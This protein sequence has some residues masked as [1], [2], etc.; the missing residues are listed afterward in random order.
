[1]RILVQPHDLAIGG[2]QLNAIDLAVAMRDRGH[3]VLM[4][5][6]PGVLVD[7]IRERGLEFIEAPHVAHRPGRAVHDRLTGLIDER[8][9]NVLHGYEWPPAV[10]AVLAARSR[11]GVAP[12][13][14]VMSMSVAPFLPHALPLV[15]GTEQIGAVERARGRTAVTVIEPPVD[16]AANDPS[17][18]DAAGFARRYGLDDGV[19]TVV[20]VSRLAQQL[21]LEGLL[22]A[23]DGAGRI[24]EP[25]R[26]VIVGDGVA[27]GDV[28]AAAQRVN[29]ERG[30]RRVI[31]TGELTDPRPAYA[32]ASAVLGM[33]GSALR[34][35]AFGKPLIVQGESGFF[36]LLTADSI[37]QFLWR[38][39]YGVGGAGPDDFV[40]ALR[41]LLQDAA[42]R[43]QVGAFSLATVRERFSLEA[44]AAAQ[45]QVY[46]EA[47]DRVRERTIRVD[48]A[49]LGRFARYHAGAKLARLRGRHS[50]DDFN[51]RPV[52]AQP[53]GQGA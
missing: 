2:S 25:M 4:F 33:G 1:M 40:R 8:G 48:L 9:L 5:G 11:P 6:N 45:E 14:T 19:P 7:T 31:L 3:D 30:E 18:A 37:D 52:A 50:T 15:V 53:V 35:L 24:P 16:L 17:A 38:G 47:L 43:E 41:P 22:A 36:E 34:A 23:I 32:A 44:A 27:R 10:D 26:L 21:K 49:S 39:W 12:V 29:S 51:A 28:E 13:A 42:L 20:V 46:T